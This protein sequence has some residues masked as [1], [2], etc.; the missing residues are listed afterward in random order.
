M[1]RMVVF[2]LSLFVLLLLFPLSLFAQEEVLPPNLDIA[3]PE[4]GDQ[5]SAESVPSG[6]DLTLEVTVTD[7]VAV[8]EVSLFYRTLGGQRYVRVPM[9]LKGK[10]RYLF[11]LPGR[12]VQGPGIE[13]YL[14]ASDKAGNT[15]TRGTPSFPRE[16]Q[17]VAE[18]HPPQVRPWYKR[19]WVWAI[20]GVVV[21]LL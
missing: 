21:L 15:V 20:V 19:P 13:Y 1:Q 10:D 17:V 3:A 2:P 16:I 9:L 5:P 7:D 12:M 18:P 8:H 4:I 6:N 11:T 14:Q